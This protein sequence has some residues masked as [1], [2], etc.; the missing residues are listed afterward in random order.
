MC[1]P[2]IIYTSRRHELTVIK[3][4]LS[5]I[6]VLHAD[7]MYAKYIFEQANEMGMLSKGY[8]WI[9]TDSVTGNPVSPL[10][11]SWGDENFNTPL[12]FSIF[13]RYFSLLTVYF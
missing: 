6:V 13:G 9:I 12:I 8:A 10:R 5:Q 4:S 2:I 11:G 1:V 3:D 7:G